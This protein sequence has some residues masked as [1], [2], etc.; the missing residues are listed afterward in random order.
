VVI[1]NFL[2]GAAEVVSSLAVGCSCSDS[3]RDFRPSN[4]SS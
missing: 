3:L 4:T 1:V 2:G